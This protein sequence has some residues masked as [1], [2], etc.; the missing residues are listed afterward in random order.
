MKVVQTVV[1]D[2][3]H[4]KLVEISRK[5]GKS[6]KQIVREA[7]EEWIAWKSEIKDDAFLNFKPE[8]FGVETDSSRL[9]KVLY[10]EERK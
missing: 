4:K 5:E 6:I 2:E 1:P 3:L 9:E 8:D 10:G 7:L